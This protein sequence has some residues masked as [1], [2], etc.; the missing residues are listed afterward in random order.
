MMKV[1]AKAAPIRPMTIRNAE[2]IGSRALIG[3]GRESRNPELA[4]R[5]GVSTC[6]R[7]RPPGDA[8]PLPRLRASGHSVKTDGDRT[9]HADGTGQLGQ[10]RHREECRSADG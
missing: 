8:A 3:A 1:A 4:G 7:E 2:R 6:V 5:P 9:G 10:A